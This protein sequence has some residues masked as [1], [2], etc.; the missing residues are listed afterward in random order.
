MK[1]AKIIIVAFCAAAALMNG[2]A[3]TGSRS[4]SSSSSYSGVYYGVVDAIET[5]RGSGGGTGDSSIGA[6]TVI[7]GVVGGVLGNQVGDGTGKD[8][9]T[10]A[11]VVGGAMVGHEMEKRN[12]SQ[13][14]QD[15]YRVRVRLDNGSFQVVTRQSIA[16]LR[17]G[18]RVR[19]DN[20]RVSRD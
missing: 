14:T 9:A 20:D 12:R 1:T 7:G 10:V 13:G 4:A 11:G 18:D 5:V 17:I 8:A 3:N 6:G 2:C 15:T 16:D 19:I